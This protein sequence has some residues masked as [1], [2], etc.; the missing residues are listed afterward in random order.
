[1]KI[2]LPCFIFLLACITSQLHGQNIS[3]E[4]G[5]TTAVYNAQTIASQKALNTYGSNA[6][7][8]NR[9]NII[10]S[11]GLE[12]NSY[13]GG[14]FHQRT[15]L[16]IPGRGLSL[17]LT[18]FYNSFNTELDYGFGRGWSMTYSLL[19]IPDSNK[20]IVRHEDGRKDIYIQNGAAYTAPAGIFDSLV[21]YQPGKFWLRDKSGTKYFFN[22]STH[23]RLTNIVDR[24]GNTI[25]ISYTGAL[26]T[27]I[28]DASGRIVQLH[29]TS[30]HLTDITDPNTSP[31]RHTTYTYDG[32]GSPLSVTD[33]LG[34]TVLYEYDF[35]QN[36]TKRTDQLSFPFTV[37]Y[38]DCIHVSSVT[39]PLNNFSFSYDT[40]Q[41]ITSSSLLVSSVLQTTTYKFDSIGN[42]TEKNG[43]CCGYHQLFEYDSLRN[44]VKK[45]DANGNIW[46]YT[47]D[48]K[49]NVLQQKDA[50]NSI[51][52]YTYE[53]TFNQVAT[54][55]DKRGFT[56]TFTYDANGNLLLVQKPL[57]ISLSFSYAGSGLIQS[58][59]DGRGFT[60]QY[61]YNSNG[62]RTQTI[63][64][65]ASTNSYT[66]DN[67]GNRLSFIDANGNTTLNTYDLLDRVTQT[68]NALG[69]VDLLGYDARGYQLS[70]TDALGHVTSNTYDALRRKTSVT[71]PR[72]TTSETFDEAGNM[73][74]VTDG[75]GHVT[76]YSYNSQNLLQ[77]ETNAL[78][79]S[80]NFTYD[81]NGN[82]LTETD[83]NGNLTTNVYDAINRKTQVTD[84]LSHNSLSVYDPNNNLVSYTDANGHTTTSTYDALNRKIT[85]Q[86][87]IGVTTY[88]YD[89]N[90]NKISTL[91][92]NGNTI[93][94]AYD[95]VNRLT[96][97]TDPLSHTLSYSYDAQGNQLTFTDG[98]G[99]VTTKTYDALN[100]EVTEA[101]GAGETKTFGYDAV[102]NKTSLTLPNG[103]VVTNTYDAGNRLISF[104]DLAGQG[105]SITYNAV[106][107]TLTET[108]G[109]GHTVTYTYNVVNKRTTA[110]DASGN[111]STFA[112][113][114]NNN[115]ASLTDRNGNVT[116][117][118]Y[119]ALNRKLTTVQP[120][121]NIISNS[122]DNVGNIISLTDD[123]GNT[124]SFVFDGN[125]RVITETYAN[126]SSKTF[127]YDGLGNK[128]TRT[129]NNGQTTNYNFDASNRLTS[130]VYPGSSDTFTYDNGGRI[131]TAVNSNASITLSH[132]NANRLQSENMNGKVTSYNY[133]VAA[134]KTFITYPGGRVIE[135]NY[136]FRNRMAAVKEGALSL[137]TFNFDPANRLQ[138]R[139]FINGANTQYAY[140]VNDW[141]TSVDHSKNGIPFAHFNYTFD[142]EG[143][144]LTSE[145]THRP[146]NS[147]KYTYDQD[148]RIT[149]YKEGTLV[150][151]AIPSPL[152]Q[153]TI[154]YDGVGNRT[155]VIHDA[156]T[157]NYTTNSV[158]QYVNIADSLF[159]NPNYDGNG[160][161][162]FDGSHNYQ[163]DTENHLV[164]VDGGSTALYKHDALGRRV[165]KVT[166]SATINYYYD[167]LR[168]IEE[169]NAS[170]AVIATYVYGSKLDEILSMRISGANFFY[171]QNSLGSIVAVT[172]ASGQVVERYEYN[173]AGAVTFYSPTYSLLT[174]SAIG[175]RI[176]FTSREYDSETKT[177][178]YRARN[179]NPKFGKFMQ[180]DPL[181]YRDGVNIYEYCLSNAINKIDPIGLY[182]LPKVFGCTKSHDKVDI[183]T[184]AIPIG[185][186]GPFVIKGWL[187]V[188]GTWDK[189]EC[190]KCCPDC[191]IKP[192]GD[193]SLEIDVELVATA[194]AGWV[195][196]ELQFYGKL[197][198]SGK[199]SL[200]YDL[201]IAPKKKFCLDLSATL[202]IGVRATA[203]VLIVSVY[204]GGEL[205]GSCSIKICL[206]GDGV[207]AGTPSCSLGGRIYAGIDGFLGKTEIDI[208]KWSASTDDK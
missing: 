141:G 153:S 147:E 194:T 191:S 7:N 43:T 165:Q 145:K 6:Q 67:V 152:T 35:V 186:I 115:L 197:K 171:H 201:C 200:E 55:T 149:N 102:G 154:N 57:G 174:S 124:T 52:T 158:N 162:L 39:S 69:Q 65:N 84:A 27:T 131:I 79:H 100:R 155:S 12:V 81:A 99:L 193:E 204:V 167:G 46:N 180:R 72:G 139:I 199:G 146:T 29:Y 134:R 103:D 97:I 19:C 75:E 34:N 14:L 56:T 132:D 189:L 74:T 26:P 89:G 11:G 122:Y 98:N 25:V 82:R 185:T 44:L 10:T 173:A 15:D 24:N 31:A 198:A 4:K 208:W 151:G 8:I 3:S 76:H 22:D 58:S 88:T 49:G 20:V 36:L 42:L 114:N 109:N 1:M 5:L 104:S 105:G 133:N 77:T 172:N 54:I 129:D 38:N 61:T 9:P 13:S 107:K 71:T 30:G 48:S 41:K 116:T 140:T 62:D 68:T 37:T 86:R 117:F 176:L 63:F 95:N 66:Y 206:D 28:S 181:E 207:S 148:Y 21:K 96:V 94:Y 163:Y 50:L 205:T 136:D 78:S 127:T 157:T 32:A 130:R 64:P 120:T 112:Y 179:Y 123:N 110:Q 159:V 18:F 106:D 195:F 23:H 70:Y 166:S 164:A 121:G 202:T 128:I 170:N 73:I 59:T 47:Y 156:V 161:M 203:S 182:C 91:N 87:P 137:A 168:I 160:N 183:S 16:R 192:W 184:P 119:D 111:S 175:N 196:A 33:Q 80:R 187:T 125:D 53:P 40:A 190:F 178:Y 150:S 17:D 142:N 85:V 177:Y 143:T 83:F 135:E 51:T 126:G 101:N 93:T 169:R 144:R 188:T 45:T 2:S 60:T 113:D 92:A 108:D 118:T 90:G 138:S